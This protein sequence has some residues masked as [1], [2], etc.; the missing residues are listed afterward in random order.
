MIKVI[1]AKEPKCLV[2]AQGD[3]KWME[4]MQSEYGSVMKNNTQDLVDRP[5]KC[6]VISIK[7]VYK[8][9]HNSNGM[10]NKYKAW[11]M[12]KGVAQIHG[13]D[14]QDTFA[15][16]TRLTT[17]RNVLDLVAQEIWPVFQMDV[18]S[19]FLNGDLKE[20]FYVE[21]PPRSVIPR[22][23]GKVCKLKKALYGLKQAPHAWY[24]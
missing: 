6:K 9:K 16:T 2:E 17:I 20:E 19:A 7:W 23:K 5:P 13:F 11:L 14:Y 4:A 3:D 8:T 15:P 22:S 12:V 24:Q 10:L 1:R 21:Q 18:K